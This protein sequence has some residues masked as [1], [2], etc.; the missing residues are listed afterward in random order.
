MKE[1][2][3]GKKRWIESINKVIGDGGE[4]RGRQRV[5]ARKKHVECR[6]GI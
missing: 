1:K 2:E 6:F 4:E 3:G 5:S